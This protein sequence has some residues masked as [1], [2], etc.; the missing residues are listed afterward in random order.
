M[1]SG[2]VAIKISDRHPNGRD[3]VRECQIGQSTGERDVLAGTLWKSRFGAKRMAGLYW[4]KI[5]VTAGW[6]LRRSEYRRD[7]IVIYIAGSYLD[8]R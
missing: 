4:E 2:V 6:R 3:D 8:P 5:L 1:A 7:G